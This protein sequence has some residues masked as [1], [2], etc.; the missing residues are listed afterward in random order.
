MANSIIRHLS[1]E[2]RHAYIAGKF[3]ARVFGKMFRLE[4]VYAS[5]W[6]VTDEAGNDIGLRFNVDRGDLKF[7]LA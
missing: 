4:H 2:I 1:L 3:S 7:F 5:Q 6:R